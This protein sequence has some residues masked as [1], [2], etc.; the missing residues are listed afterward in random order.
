MPEHQIYPYD[1]FCRGD[2]RESRY[3]QMVDKSKRVKRGI[4]ADPLLGN[5]YND[6]RSDESIDLSS[7]ERS[8]GMSDGRSDGMSDGMSDGRS[9]ESSGDEK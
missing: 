9:D 5:S 3:V 8:D 6:V 7:D 4:V 2:A 1:N